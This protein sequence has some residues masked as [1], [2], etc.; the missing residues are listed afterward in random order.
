[1]P[2]LHRPFSYFGAKHEIASHYP[3]PSYPIIVEPFAGS[4]GYSCLHHE[5]RVIL[6]D[7]DLNVVQAWRT[8]IE[9]EQPLPAGWREAIKLAPALVGFWLANGRSVPAKQPSSWMLSGQRPNAY[10]G[11]QAAAKTFEVSRAIKHWTVTAWPWQMVPV[12]EATWFIDPPY[13]SAGGRAYKRHR[14]DYAK[15]AAWC[16]GLPGQVIVCEEAG[17]DWL[18][19]E[20]LGSFRCSPGKGRSHV[21]EVVWTRS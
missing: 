2:K 9:M 15:L 20:P 3:E 16:K 4:A 12:Q 10:W 7:L 14:I 6:N 17:A 19:F 13:S 11:E 8:L 21:E 5:R 18:P 1:M